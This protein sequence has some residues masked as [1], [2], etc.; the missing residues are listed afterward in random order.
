MF[1]EDVPEVFL[2]DDDV[3]FLTP[4][5]S[6]AV[7]SGL[8]HDEEYLADEEQLFLASGPTTV[9]AGDLAGEPG[10]GSDPLAKDGTSAVAEETPSEPA[11]ATSKTER[12]W[13][14]AWP[15]RAKLV[16]L[17]CALLAASLAL[18]GFATS[19]ILSRFLVSQVDEQLLDLTRNVPR[20]RQ[21]VGT[22]RGPSD[23]YVGFGGH[24][25]EIDDL[26][27]GPTRDRFGSPD[28]SNIELDETIQIREPRPIR[29]LQGQVEQG[30]WH[31]SPAEFFTVR[32]VG[33]TEPTQWR[34]AAMQIPFDDFP[35]RAPLDTRGADEN[36]I[37]TLYVGMPLAGVHQALVMLVRTLTLSGLGLIALGGG[38]AFLM[39][40]RSLRPLQEIE[41]T[42]AAIADGD[43]SQRIQVAAPPSTEVGSLAVSLN[44]ML[45]QI[46]AA[47]ATQ[48]TAQRQMRRFVSDA[49][50]EL[51]TP[52][53]AVRGYSELYRMGALPPDE[54]PATMGRIED[55]S[56]RMS[57]L[58][59][60]LLT[61]A[62]LDEGQEVRRDP[63]DLTALVRGVAQDLHALD[64]TREV[65]VLQ[66]PPGE[67][68]AIVGDNQRLQQVLTNLIG[69]V[70][71][72]TPKG[73]PVEIALSTTD[74]DA[75]IE[76]RDHGPGIA[77]AD[78][79]R[80]FERFY[81]ADESRCRENGSGGSGLGLAIVAAIV[82]AHGGSVRALPTPGGGLTVRLTLPLE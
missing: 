36:L 80:I 12:Y 76:V 2:E 20:L 33:G 57:A 3:L 4:N 45:A 61:L 32:G 40:R 60:E 54:V 8:A 82:G 70:A 14:R 79:E 73:T 19:T 27:W 59:E 52:L 17:I 1:V 77:S 9:A 63:V 69:N 6:A 35:L 42:A 55:A 48:D 34:V 28:L 71:R 39:V 29:P 41:R 51:R 67:D 64:P 49:S 15:L 53:A 62:R 23:Y 65:T 68:I 26:M 24:D 72:H 56:R 74:T 16:V 18:L 13:F 38:G 78:E 66:E 75:V 11:E 25:D 30:F 46:E 21:L 37:L 5:E 43:L 31:H 44:V 58:V 50:H 47:F 22:E 10:K 81:R 7:E